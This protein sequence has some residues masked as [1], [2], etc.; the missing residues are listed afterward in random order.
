LARWLP[1][2]NVEFLG[3]IDH[4]VKIRGFRIEL[5]EIEEHLNRHPG[6]KEVV[7][8]NRHDRGRQYLCAYFTARQTPDKTILS[9]HEL[10]EYLQEKLPDYMIPA[11]F[12]KVEKIPLNPSGKVDRKM[13]PHPLESDFHSDG[14]YKP[15]QSGMQRMIAEIWQEVLGREK[16][17]IQDNFF[18][19]GGNSLDIVTVCNKLKEKLEKEI[20]V[21]TLFTYP[22]IRSLEHYLTR[23]QGEE[24][25]QEPPSDLSERIDEAKDLI[26]LRL[27]KLGSGNGD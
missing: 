10:K 14:T 1:E 2:G 15:P 8:I 12:V 4:Q 24:S 19:L 11:C 17:G 7:V 22:T 3:R 5:G 20:P 23:N 9:V 6:I 21:V 18:D 26:H 25:V 27:K 16:I 13:L